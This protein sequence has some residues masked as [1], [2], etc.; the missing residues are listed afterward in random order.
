MKQ[1]RLA[2]AALLVAFTLGCSSKGGEDHLV[3][4]GPDENGAQ[5]ANIH[6]RG[7]YYGTYQAAREGTEANASGTTSLAIANASDSARAGIGN[8]PQDKRGEHVTRVR[9]DVPAS[10]PFV[11]PER[12]GAP[13]FVAQAPAPP[14]GVQPP[15]PPAIQAPQGGPPAYVP[16][17]AMAQGFGPAQANPYYQQ[18]SGQPGQGQMVQAGSPT[19]DNRIL[20]N[21]ANVGAL[22]QTQLDTAYT[23]SQINQLEF[24][25]RAAKSWTDYQR[26]A[27]AA[28]TVQTWVG[29][30]VG[31]SNAVQ[32]QIAGWG[33]I[34]RQVDFARHGWFGGAP[35]MPGYSGYYPGYVPLARPVMPVVP[36][37]PCGTT[38]WGNLFRARPAT[39]LQAPNM[40]PA[41]AP[42]RRPLPVTKPPVTKPAV[43][44]KK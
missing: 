7:G 39:P 18:Q 37:Q 3:R 40:K 26:N 16:P 32:G 20:Q 19:A 24:Q 29:T 6:H 27:A 43:Q 35:M 23:Q 8:Q 4:F 38:F 21:Q 5:Y 31:I 44:K 2:V 15:A 28:A 25:D 12:Q 30:G 34:D 22:N 13:A 11:D 9:L 33:S 41:A 10:Q 1:A 14:Q 42:Q 36:Q 17:E